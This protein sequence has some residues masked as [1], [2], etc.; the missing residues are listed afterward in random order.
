MTLY[1]GALY[2]WSPLHCRASIRKRGLKPT[3]D[4]AVLHRPVPVNLG[5]IEMDHEVVTIKA[6]CLGSS[7]ALAWGLSGVYDTKPGDQWDLWEVNLTDADEVHV[8]P[9]Q[10]QR[11]DEVRVLG[12]IPRSRIWH[13]GMRTVGRLR[14]FHAP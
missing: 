3:C 1:L 7:P 11:L 5:H 6:V 13:V 2:H 9:E 14:Y 12:P 8:M 10:G 4:T